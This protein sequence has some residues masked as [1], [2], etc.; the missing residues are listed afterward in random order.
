MWKTAQPQENADEIMHGLS[1]SSC[2]ISKY[3]V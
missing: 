2:Q 3:L 1:F